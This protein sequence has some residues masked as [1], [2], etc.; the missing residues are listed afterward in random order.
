MSLNQ[1]TR[2]DVELMKQKCSLRRA[3]R[4]T[5]LTMPGKSS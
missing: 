3:K 2:C 1:E 5:E 4:N